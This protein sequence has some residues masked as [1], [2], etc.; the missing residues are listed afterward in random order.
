MLEIV[1]V[2]AKLMVWNVKLRPR[3]KWECKGAERQEEKVVKVQEAERICWLSFEGTPSSV[4][5]QL[6]IC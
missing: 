2:A 4:G 5:F 3:R 1:T 6:G